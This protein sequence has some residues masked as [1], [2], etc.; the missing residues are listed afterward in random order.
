MVGGTALVATVWLL[1]LLPQL[2][3]RAGP[4]LGRPFKYAAPTV[5]MEERQQLR[6]QRYFVALNVFNNEEVLTFVLPQLRR[7]LKV[8]GHSRVYV[9]VYENGTAL[10]STSTSTS[11]TTPTAHPHAPLQEALIARLSC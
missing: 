1:L 3:G 7:L 10:L 5:S 11:T 8:L 2:S 6:S 9:S 4:L